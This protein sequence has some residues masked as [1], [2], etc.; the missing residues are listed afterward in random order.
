MTTTWYAAA[1]MERE[2]GAKENILIAVL[3]S[4]VLLPFDMAAVKWAKRWGVPKEVAETALSREDAVAEARRVLQN[5]R[6]DKAS[7]DMVNTANA[8]AQEMMMD[9]LPDD[10]DDQQA[11][12][13]AT[14]KPAATAADA[15]SLNILARTL[16]AE[17]KGEGESGMRAIA[18]VIYNRGGGSVGGMVNAVKKKRQ[19]SCWNSMDW[20]R[21]QIK[22]KSGRDWDAAKSIASEMVQGTFSPTTNALFYYNPDRVS[23]A[24][25]WSKLEDAGRVGSHLFFTRKQ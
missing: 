10:E 3:T 9:P 8:I 7:E 11:S 25:D 23:P 4:L 13:S 18:S 22:E 21:F 19:F 17:G 2:A 20:S 12:P 24:W 1:K 14:G 15:T 6:T 16:W 5:S